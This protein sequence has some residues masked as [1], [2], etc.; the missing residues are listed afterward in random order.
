MTDLRG[1]YSYFSEKSHMKHPSDKH[2]MLLGTQANI[3]AQSIFVCNICE[4]PKQICRTLLV[5]NHGRNRKADA[6][7]WNFSFCDACIG[8]VHIFTK[9]SHSKKKISKKF[10]S[11]FLLVDGWARNCGKVDPHISWFLVEMRDSVKDNLFSLS[12]FLFSRIGITL[13]STHLISCTTSK[14]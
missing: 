8:T 5:W 9:T 6:D 2:T 3:Y 12:H 4:I 10:Y 1:K 14:Q 7:V 13:R 11:K